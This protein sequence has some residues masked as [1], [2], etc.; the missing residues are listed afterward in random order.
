[1][2][3]NGKK[4]QVFLLIRMD[5]FWGGGGRI[6]VSNI[7]LK[8]LAGGWGAGVFGFDRIG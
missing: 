2:V 1:M 5:G 3:K 8:S 4:R 7:G 6:I